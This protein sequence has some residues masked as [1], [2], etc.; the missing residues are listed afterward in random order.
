MTPN[1]LA[2]PCPDETCLQTQHLAKNKRQQCNT[3]AANVVVDD[4]DDYYYYYY[5][6]QLALH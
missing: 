1:L 6:H 3:A 4:D 5:Y 2:P